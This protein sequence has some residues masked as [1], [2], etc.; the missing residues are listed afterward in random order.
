MISCR[1]SSVG[2][3]SLNAGYCA[4]LKRKKG[5]F[6]KISTHIGLFIAPVAAAILLIGGCGSRHSGKAQSST[7]EPGI[8]YSYHLRGIVKALPAALG[9]LPENVTIKVGPIAHWVG[10]S[11]KIEPMMAMTMPYQLAHGVTL[12]GIATGDKVAFTYKVNWTADRMVITRIRTLPAGTVINF[13]APADAPTSGP[14][15]AVQ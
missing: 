2:C 3:V 5:F 11:G 4:G 8:T 15:K 12:H 6:M 13:S 10:M 1:V 14:S 9:Q 7:T